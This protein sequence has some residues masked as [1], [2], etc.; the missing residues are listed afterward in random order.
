MDTA[1]IA[2]RMEAHTVSLVLP[3]RSEL[4]PGRVDA[5][6]HGYDDSDHDQGL[7]Y[8]LVRRVDPAFPPRG[9]GGRAQRGHSRPDSRSQV[10]IFTVSDSVALRRT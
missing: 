7:R 2:I 9:E 10:A 5:K 6:D 4:V 1:S 3:Q 8:G